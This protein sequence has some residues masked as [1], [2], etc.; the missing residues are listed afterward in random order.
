MSSAF[1]H[2]IAVLENP[3]VIPKS[4]TVVFDAQL[5]LPSSEPALIGTLR[6]FNDHNIQLPD[7]CCCSVD[8][9]VARSISTVETY[10]QTLS[11]LDYHIMGDIIMLRPL[12]PPEGFDLAHQS[13]V[14]I[15]GVPNNINS[16]DATFNLTAEQYVSATKSSEVFPTRCLIPDIAKFKKYKPI[17]AKGRSVSVLGYLTGLERNEDKTVKH[18][19]IDVDSVTFLGPA[20]LTAPKAEESP[21]KI[22]DGTPARLKFTGF[23]GSQ[24][25]ADSGEPPSK[26]RKSGDDR[27]VDETEVQD[28]GEGPSNGRRQTRH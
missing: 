18:F 25:Q 17:P 12:G 28:K 19:I 14:T 16:D 20:G 23:F 26:K 7:V 9:R 2:G 4:K 10:S 3:R 24:G 1:L 11:P 27:A 8:V 5:F 15:C 21:K 22:S 13:V 6:Y